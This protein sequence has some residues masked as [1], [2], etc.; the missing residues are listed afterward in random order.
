MR[1][2]PIF[3]HT[4]NNDKTLEIF[5]SLLENGKKMI[6]RQHGCL[7]LGSGSISSWRSTKLHADDALR[8]KTDSWY[9][10]R[11]WN[12]REGS[13]LCEGYNAFVLLGSHA[14]GQVDAKSIEPED[15]KPFAT[16]YL[17]NLFSDQGRVLYFIS[18]KYPNLCCMHNP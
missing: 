15:M 9:L 3:E 13:G 17:F 11:G 2:F 5:P 1:H 18:H 4:N 16:L 6:I 8:T 7:I 14:S 10:R 12:Q